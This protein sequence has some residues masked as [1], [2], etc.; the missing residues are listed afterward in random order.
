MLL[1]LRNIAISVNNKSVLIIFQ[2]TVKTRRLQGPRIV[3]YATL[4]LGR[5]PIHC[6]L[7]KP[8]LSIVAMVGGTPLV[9]Q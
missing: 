8:T 3:V 6:L 4:W 2:N 5:Q 7:W 1:L 9:L